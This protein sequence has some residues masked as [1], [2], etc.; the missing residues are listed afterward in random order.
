M[1]NEHGAPTGGAPDVG[2]GARRAEV[3]WAGHF[4]P[5]PCQLLAILPA[6]TGPLTGIRV[7]DF[8]WAL[9]GPFGTM[10]LA[11]LGGEVWKVE[12]VG[13]TEEARGP[14]PT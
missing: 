3:G 7:L 5:S 9:A 14:G 4:A 12:P 11:D 10:I 13:M 1:A 8:T 2:S 6:M